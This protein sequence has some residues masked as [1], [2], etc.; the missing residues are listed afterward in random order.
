MSTD[1]QVKKTQFQSLLAS[2]EVA[3]EEAI[4]FAEQESVGHQVANAISGAAGMLDPNKS[5]E[6]RRRILQVNPALTRAQS[7]RFNTKAPAFIGSEAKKKKPV[8]VEDKQRA[9]D[10]IIESSLTEGQEKLLKA[11]EMYSDPIAFQADNTVKGMREMAKEAEVN[12][13]GSTSAAAIA[14]RLFE[15]AKELNAEAQG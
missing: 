15:A 5:A 4:K 2:L 9:A 3:F 6:F 12:L 1:A 13:Q 7:G 10:A 14:A 11:V 8:A